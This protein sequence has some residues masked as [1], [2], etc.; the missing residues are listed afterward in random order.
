[1]LGNLTYFAFGEIYMSLT[2]GEETSPFGTRPSGL[3]SMYGQRPIGG[4]AFF[5]L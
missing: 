5:F 3:K 1:M 4:L 2:K